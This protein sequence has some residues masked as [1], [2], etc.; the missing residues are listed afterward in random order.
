MLY[1]QNRTIQYAQELATWWIILYQFRKACLKNNLD[2][3][4]LFCW[5][6]PT[7]FPYPVVK[8]F[9]IKIPSNIN[10]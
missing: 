3:I 5:E 4:L 9:D 6:K 8:I 2:L 10:I 7:I 1:S